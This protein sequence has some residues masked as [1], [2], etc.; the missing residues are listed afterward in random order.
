MPG[1]STGPGVPALA[2]LWSMEDRVALVTGGARGIGLATASRF[3]EAGAHV[4]LADLDGEA[5][6]RARLALGGATCTTFQ[7][8]LTKAGATARLV[9][10]AVERWG[11]ID[12]VF[13]NAGYNWNAP[14]AEMT[15]EQF[16][17]MLDV[18]LVTAFRLLRDAAPVLTRT[19][20]TAR[21]VVNMSS[22]SGTMGLA[23]QA[24]Y[25]SAKAG[26]IGLTKQLAKEWGPFGVNVNAVAPGLIE[27]RLT[28]SAESAGTIEIDG[29]AITLGVAPGRQE[30]ITAHI[31]LGRAGS[32]DEVARV[33]HFL[34]SGASDYITGQVISIN[35]GLA[36]GMSS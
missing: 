8:D 7:E 34:S 19:A 4:V 29:R 23:N 20:S 1:G 14:I 27:T 17:A 33:V 11:R 2:E 21:K 32:P 30:Q 9:S 5:L 10:T 3:V 13:N 15:D 12:V 24:N 6:A 25:S 28:A 36:M 18:H 26:L 22:V 31:A 16:D 35:G